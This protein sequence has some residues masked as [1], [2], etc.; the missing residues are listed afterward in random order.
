VR[1]RRPVAVAGGES[2]LDLCFDTTTHIYQAPFQVKAD[3]GVLIIDDFGRQRVP[4][5]DL[6]NR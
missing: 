3:G 4:P 6:L 5:R 2:T 1:V